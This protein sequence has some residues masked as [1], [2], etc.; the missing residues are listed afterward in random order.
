MTINVGSNY[1][2]RVGKPKKKRKKRRNARRGK[3]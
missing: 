2:S 3:R 1:T